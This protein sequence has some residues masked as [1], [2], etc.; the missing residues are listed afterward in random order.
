MKKDQQCPICQEGS[1]N[2]WV[3]KD[4]V[5]YRSETAELDPH[6][7]MCNSCGSE[8]VDLRQLRKNKRYIVAFKKRVEG[9]L[10]GSEVKSAREHL[11]LKQLDAARIFGGGRLV[12]FSKY[13]SDAMDR[14][15]RVAVE[16]SKAFKYLAKRA[17]VY[18]EADKTH[19]IFTA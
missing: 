18:V 7:S 1:I 13:E 4:R 10:A 15:L 16:V 2:E 11:G 3:S 9:L 5:D 12:A 8:Q 14:P 17:Q 19:Y 6:F